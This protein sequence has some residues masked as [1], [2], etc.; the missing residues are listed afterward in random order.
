MLASLLSHPSLPSSSSQT[1]F[2]CSYVHL[3]PCP[4][5]ARGVPVLFPQPQARP[6]LWPHQTSH[7]P[8]YHNTDTPC[9]PSHP[10]RN[11]A[12]VHISTTVGVPGHSGICCCTHILCTQPQTSGFSGES[13]E[14][15]P[16]PLVATPRATALEVLHPPPWPAIQSYK[17]GPEQPPSQSKL[18][19]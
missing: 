12:C 4:N 1:P 16:C 9:P 11:A 19:D 17:S 5:K 8:A 3:R 2:L 18:S 13:P 15:L 6:Q 14:N 10:T 7:K